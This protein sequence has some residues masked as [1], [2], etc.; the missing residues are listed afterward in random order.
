MNKKLETIP[1][2][3]QGYRADRDKISI[4]KSALQCHGIPKRQIGVG[5]MKRTRRIV[6]TRLIQ[7]GSARWIA[8]TQPFQD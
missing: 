3:L 5:S 6:N 1:T 8:R 7:A 4:E 2:D